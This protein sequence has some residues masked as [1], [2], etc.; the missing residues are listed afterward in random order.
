MRKFKSIVVVYR[1]LVLAGVAWGFLMLT[2]WSYPVTQVSKPLDECKSVHWKDMPKGCII[3]IPKIAWANYSKYQGDSLYQL[4]YSDLWSTSYTN[5]RDIGAGSSPG[6][7]IV[8]SKGT[9]VYA[10]SDGTVVQAWYKFGIGNSITVKHA[11]KGWYIYSSYSHLDEMFFALGD[12]VKEWQLIGKIGNTGTTYGQYGNHLDFQITTTAQWF[13]PYSYY[14]CNI[15]L[16]YYDI[17]NSTM[18]KSY[19]L[20]NTMD[21]I[22][23]LENWWPSSSSSI[24]TQI[25]ATHGSATTTSEIKNTPDM[26]VASKPDLLPPKPVINTNPNDVDIRRTTTTAPAEIKLQTPVINQ[27]KPIVNAS[28]PSAT[29]QYQIM[30]LKSQEIV[31]IKRRFVFFIKVYDLDKKVPYIGKLAHRIVLRDSKG[32]IAFDSP[33]ITYTNSGIIK[34]TALWLKSWYT[35]LKVEIAGQTLGS[36]GITLE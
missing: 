28:K 2:W 6:A 31:Q 17:I 18:C 26:S 4:I 21:P 8:S 3:D 24:L 10:I 19:M 14:D 32:I 1:I 29:Y 13:Y 15:W 33:V 20:A 11:Y 9:P 35:D 36:Y 30:W 5:G 7:D 34:V 25:A 22:A 23:L 16:S 27:T 12:T